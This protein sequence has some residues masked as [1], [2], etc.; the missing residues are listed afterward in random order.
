MKII[1]Q[2][3]ELLSSLFT[4]MIGVY[5][6]ITAIILLVFLNNYGNMLF[7]CLM[8]SMAILIFERVFRWINF[9]R[10][11]ND[12]IT[13]H[14]DHITIKSN[15]KPRDI[16]YK[17]IKDIIQNEKKNTLTFIMSGNDKVVVKYCF[18][19]G[20]VRKEI[21]DYKNKYYKD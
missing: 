7:I 3:N 5:L 4:R 13:M 21:L 17:Y 1:G 12:L 9:K 18:D 15:Y 19:I 8:I 10:L 11:P 14:R 20:V 16:D 6:L 2:K